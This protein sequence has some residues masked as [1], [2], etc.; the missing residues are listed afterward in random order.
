MLAIAAD[1]GTETL[2]SIA[3]SDGSFV[4]M[5]N[6]RWFK[7]NEDRQI[8]LDQSVSRKKR[9]SNAWRRA[10]KTAA[11][12]KSRMARKRLDHH[13]KLA[14]NIAKEAAIFATE[15]LTI[16][17]MTASASGTVEEPGRQVAQKSGLNREILD[18]A[19]ALLLSLI[20][21]KVLETG[22]QYLE[23]PTRTLK[24][25]QRC[26][27]CWR[28]KKKPLSERAHQCACGCTMGR[29]DASALVVLRWAMQEIPGQ[30]LAWAA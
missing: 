27:N 24:P 13:H 8:E 7:S 20:A 28:L 22:G 16:K 9:G 25:S 21:Y 12:F 29:D 14:A 1:W 15:K 2:L 30:E 18:T 23:A 5:D 3:K 11:R 10:K 17:N 19:P 26:P 6:P 4:Q